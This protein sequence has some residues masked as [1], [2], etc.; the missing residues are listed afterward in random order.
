MSSGTTFCKNASLRKV[1]GGYLLSY[2]KHMI[3]DDEYDGMRYVGEEKEVF[4][5]GTAAVKRLD[6]LFEKEME[7][8]AMLEKDE[9]KTSVRVKRY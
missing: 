9:P 8:K 7:G 6:E 4:T 1:K 2:D 3:G 5:S